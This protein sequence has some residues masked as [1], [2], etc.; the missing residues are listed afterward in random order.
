MFYVAALM[1]LCC[2]AETIWVF[3]LLCTFRFRHYIICTDLSHATWWQRWDSNPRHRNMNDPENESGTVP[4]NDPENES[5][6]EPMNDPENESGTEPM[7][8]PENE[9]GTEPMNDPENESGTEPENDPENESGTEPMNDPE[10]EMEV[11]IS[12]EETS[13]EEK[14][15]ENATQG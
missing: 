4:M 5:G 13:E 14:T 6:T 1:L 3:I 15:N 10:S 11:I 12:M 2:C 9:S 7:N 8:D